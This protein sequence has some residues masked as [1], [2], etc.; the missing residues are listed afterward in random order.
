MRVIVG[1]YAMSVEF[2][3]ITASELDAIANEM[4]KAVYATLTAWPLSSQNKGPIRYTVEV[5]KTSDLMDELRD[6]LAEQARSDASDGLMNPD[7]YC[8]RNRFA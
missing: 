8:E 1:D 3:G 2:P 4:W 6:H 7:R 5:E